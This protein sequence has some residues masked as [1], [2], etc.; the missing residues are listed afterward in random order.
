M[1]VSIVVPNR[2]YGQY[3]PDCLDSIA[4]QTYKNIEVLLA[5][6]NSDD[7][8]LKILEE[9]A[10]KYCWQIYSK[11]D[12]GTADAINEGLQISSGDI[13][14]WLNS[15]DF[16]L[17]KR[18][19][20][21]VVDIFVNYPDV[22]IVSLGGYFTDF[23]KKFLHPVKEINNPFFRQ[24]DSQHRGICLQPSTFWKKE[25]FEQVKFCTE[26]KYTF[27][28]YFFT[29][30]SQKF[31]LILDQTIFISGYRW[32]GA[33]LSSGVKSERVKD[34]AKLNLLLFGRGFR[35]FYLCYLSS[36][37]QGI[38]FLAPKFLS[39]RINLIIYVMNNSLSFIS[40]YRIPSI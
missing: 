35:Y 20:E 31:N 34:I 13:Q 7:S 37:I 9:Y 27:D 26:L 40:F 17:S 3:L 19:I 22:D 24:S 1:K 28:T 14:C 10:S 25:V 2:N 15:D 4:M 33:N 32:H 30:A 16:F 21:T 18:S 29:I 36:L 11:N 5:D 23:Q 12:S 8:S 38:E 6:G 39:S